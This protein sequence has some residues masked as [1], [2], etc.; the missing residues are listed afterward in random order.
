[1]FVTAAV[2]RRRGERLSHEARDRLASV[3]KACLASTPR[4]GDPHRAPVRRSAPS[5]GRSP[6]RTKKA[7]PPAAPH[8]GRASAM[9]DGGA[10]AVSRGY[11]LVGRACCAHATRRR[12]DGDTPRCGL[13]HPSPHR[14][15]QSHMP[16]PRSFATR[17]PLAPPPLE[18]GRSPSPAFG[19][20][21]RVGIKARRERRSPPGA[22]ERADLPFSRGGGASG[23]SSFL[24]DRQ[25]THMRLPCPIGGGWP[26]PATAGGGRVGDECEPRQFTPT[27][28]A[29]LGT[30]P[31]GGGMELAGRPEQLS[32]P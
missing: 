15:G 23:M 13:V 3:P 4:C 10:L 2:E 5:W 7:P 27:R 24:N 12:D 14:A 6:K 22:Q 16:L 18:K 26:T 25:N 9:R 28:L 17:V 30:L 1:M 31:C 29:S 32:A 20:A 11:R 19:R 21:R 8:K